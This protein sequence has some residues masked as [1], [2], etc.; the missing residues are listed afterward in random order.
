[1]SCCPDAPLWLADLDVLP[2]LRVV[3]I[4][5]EAERYDVQFVDGEHSPES[6]LHL[7]PQPSNDMVY[8]RSMFSLEGLPDEL[9]VYVPL[10]CSV[11][12]RFVVSGQLQLAP[13]SSDEFI[14]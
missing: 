12:A 9:R 10:F 7:V 13:H 1:M 2:T 5:K 4:A 3:D 6:R 14:V 11:R 8:A